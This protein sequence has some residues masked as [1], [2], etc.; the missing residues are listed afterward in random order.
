MHAF[1]VGQEGGHSGA[2]A[3]EHD[4]IEDL[5]GGAHDHHHPSAHFDGEGYPVTY[6]YG[7]DHSAMMDEGSSEI[8]TD[9]EEELDYQVGV[10]CKQKIA[11]MGCG[12]SSVVMYP[13][14]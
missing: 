4:T 1:L 10:L 11:C 7:H 13:A 9:L 6:T 8:Y 14:A 2:A 3:V 12:L 5:L